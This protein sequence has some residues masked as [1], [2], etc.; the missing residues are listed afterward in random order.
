MQVWAAGGFEATGDGR[1][2]FLS[3]KTG[4]YYKDFLG[5]DEEVLKAVLEF[6]RRLD[7]DV[8]NVIT[9]TRFGGVV[10]PPGLRL[11]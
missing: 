9:Q 1:L 8:S 11:P 7:Y 10:E 6:M 3:T 2:Y 5:K 4:H